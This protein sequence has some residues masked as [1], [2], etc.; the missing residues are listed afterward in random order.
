MKINIFQFSFYGEP[1]LDPY[2]IDK[3]AYIRSEVKNAVIV[4]NTNT[5]L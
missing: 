4:L 1:L 5:N 2:L 3:I